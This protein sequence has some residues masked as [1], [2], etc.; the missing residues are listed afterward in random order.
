MKNSLKIHPRARRALASI[1]TPQKEKFTPDPFQEEAVAY[2]A[3]KDV[4][5]SAPTGSGKTWIATTALQR[6]LSNGQ[7]GWYATPLKALSNVLYADFGE[8]FGRE[9]VGILTGDRRENSH[10]PIIVGTTEI[11]RNHLY[12]A[13]HRGEDLDVDLVVLDE[14]HYL[15]EED[16]GMVW[17]EVMIYLPSRVR[18]LLLSATISNG[19]EI[20]AWLEE[21][22]DVACHVVTSFER[23]VPLYPLFIFP[24]GEVVPLQE[25]SGLSPRIE[26]FESG[27]RT[28]RS[29]YGRENISIDQIMT[30]LHELDLLPAIFFLKSRADCNRSLLSCRI[31][32]ERDPQRRETIGTALKKHLKEYPFLRGHPQLHYIRSCGVA[33]HHAGQL[34]YWKLLVERLMKEGC[35]DA[36]FFNVDRGGGS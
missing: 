11:L 35:L 5:V 17:E 26:R 1:G 22:R 29:R 32:A 4:V 27:E 8:L 23:P 19:D 24:H 28:K 25:G 7:K 30:V 2:I 10:A 3:E 14:A 36:I 31:D 18:L 20:A 15:G 12:D 9:N 13:M 34:P 33:A 21:I 6:I 16:R